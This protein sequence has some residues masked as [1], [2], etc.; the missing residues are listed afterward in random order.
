LVRVRGGGLTGGG[1]GSEEDT[2]QVEADHGVP[3]LGLH[4]DHKGVLGDA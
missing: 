1:L 3:L 2:A 4:G